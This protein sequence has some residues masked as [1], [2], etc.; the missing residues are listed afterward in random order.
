M[1]KLIFTAAATGLFAAGCALG[2]IDGQAPLAVTDGELTMIVASPLPN[3]KFVAGQDVPF[4]IEIYSGDKTYLV[5]HA[6]SGAHFHVRIDQ[7]ETVTY[8]SDAPAFGYTIPD[9]LG[10]GNHAFRVEYH[11]DDGHTGR[12]M[13][14]VP[15]RVEASTIG[16]SAGLN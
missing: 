3:Q 1:R 6:S 13:V 2:P 5:S 10:A 15:F 8:V 9:G 11:D 16:A 4:E 12:F 14:S 7:V